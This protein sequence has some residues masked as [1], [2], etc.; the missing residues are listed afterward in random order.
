MALPSRTITIDE[1]A[2]FC[3]VCDWTKGLF[4]CEAWGSPDAPPLRAAWH[5]MTTRSLKTCHLD[6]PR[7]HHRISFAAYVCE[8][9][10]RGAVAGSRHHII[11]LAM[12]GPP[13]RDDDTPLGHK[14]LWDMLVPMEREKD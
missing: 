8:W 2:L 14:D 4:T 12:S 13:W 9:E 7:F 5:A 11:T 10:F 6:D 1:S 3:A